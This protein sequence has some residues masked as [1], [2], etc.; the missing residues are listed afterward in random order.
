MPNVT[1]KVQLGNFSV[2]VTGPEKYVE[3]KIEEFIAKHKKNNLGDSMV[4]PSAAQAVSKP[5]DKALAPSEFIRK[6][7]SPKS[8]A[9]L[10]LALAYFLENNL[11]KPNFTTSDIAELCKNAKQSK[12]TNISDTVSKLVKQGLMMGAGENEENKRTF[13]L[14]TSGE[15]IVLNLI[16]S[17]KK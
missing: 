16:A 3:N 15:D 1:I 12:F 10:A 14:T 6:K 7:V 13:A 4:I 5:I 11:D 9:D 8:Q 17:S 2:E